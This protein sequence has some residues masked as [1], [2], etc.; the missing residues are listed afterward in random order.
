MFLHKLVD[1]KDGLVDAGKYAHVT[2]YYSLL[3]K[4]MD[5]L[6]NGKAT[7]TIKQ[8]SIEDVKRVNDSFDELSRLGSNVIFVESDNKTIGVKIR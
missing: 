5:T 2:T 8:I 1:P 7:A 6:N 4:G 3:S